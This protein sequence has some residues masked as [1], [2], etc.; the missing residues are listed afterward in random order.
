MVE[1]KD[2]VFYEFISISESVP[3]PKEPQDLAIKITLLRLRWLNER[4][5][6]KTDSDIYQGLRERVLVQEQ[7]S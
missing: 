5:S 6:N 1:E 4:S 3:V 2:W 7:Q